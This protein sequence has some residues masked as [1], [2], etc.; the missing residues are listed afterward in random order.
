MRGGIEMRY[1]SKERF[2]FNTSNNQGNY[3]IYGHRTSL[4]ISGPSQNKVI[5]MRHPARRQEWDMRVQQPRERNFNP[6]ERTHYHFDD[7]QPW[8]NEASLQGFR[9]TSFNSRK[10]TPH[11][12]VQRISKVEKLKRWF[13]SEL[14][15]GRHDPYPKG[16]VKAGAVYLFLLIMVMVNGIK[17]N[18]YQFVNQVTV[19][20]NELVVDALIQQSSR[21]EPF[22]RVKDVFRQREAIE[23]VIVS[24]NPMVESVT[25][26]RP[27]GSTLNIK[28][29]EHRFIGLTEIN[30]DFYPVS[31][32]GEVISTERP[33]LDL[34]VAADKLPI[35]EGFNNTGELRTIAESLEQIPP[36]ILAQMQ[37]IRAST[38]INKPQGIEVQMKD[39]NIIMA[40][41]STFAQKVQHYP[42]ILNQLEGRTGIINLEVGAYFTPFE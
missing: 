26:E 23:R 9:S 42:K 5:S 3:S 11:S 37:N 1:D 16:I 41:A 39:G 32:S 2:N 18:P 15:R 4:N 22:D 38:D 28:V 34:A 24:E 8:R 25:F 31:S 19:S 35:L 6:Y 20:G 40:I 36:E 33:E 7:F 10:K 17:I 30:S 21:I 27:N 13:D 12:H 14:E 29:S